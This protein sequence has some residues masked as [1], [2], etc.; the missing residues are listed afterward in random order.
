MSGITPTPT[1]SPSET[2]DIP[3]SRPSAPLPVARLGGP[4]ALVLGSLLAA[5][6]MA[7]HLP[8]MAEDV[9]IPIAIAAAPGRWLASHLLMGFGFTL[10]AIGAASA[11]SSLRRD[12]GATLT[13]LGSVA[14]AL[15]AM[16]MALG[17]MAHGAVGFALTEVEFATS[18]AVH[19]AYFEHP[20]I[21]AVNAGPMLVSVGMLVLGAGLLRSRAHPRWVGIVVMLTPIAVNAG[22]SLGLPPLAPGVPFAIGMTTFAY[23]LIRIPQPRRVHVDNGMS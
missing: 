14:T 9:G 21:L 13:A 6:G 8:A 15:G 4:V 12:R 19:E 20:A 7:L 3:S 11:L 18:L 2:A 23:A 16:T 1:P 10:V 22:F 5:A 17:D